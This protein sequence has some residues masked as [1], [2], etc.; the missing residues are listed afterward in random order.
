MSLWALGNCDDIFLNTQLICQEVRDICTKQSE[1]QTEWLFK[2]SMLK[3]CCQFTHHKR[4]FPSSCPVAMQS[5]LGWQATHV[6]VFLP[7]FLLFSLRE[8]LLTA[9]QARHAVFVRKSGFAFFA[10]HDLGPNMITS[11][12]ISTAF[13]VQ[14]QRADGF[15]SRQGSPVGLLLLEEVDFKLQTFSWSYI[16]TLSER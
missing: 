14:W 5:S 16:F 11:L 15:I 6:N 1:R 2:I 13:C 9:H 7:P 12:C 8:N 3:P 10:I 4:I